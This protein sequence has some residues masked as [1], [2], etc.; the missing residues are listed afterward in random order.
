[1]VYHSTQWSDRR[2]VAKIFGAI[3]KLRHR[4][5]EDQIYFPT[6]PLRCL[7]RSVPRR[8]AGLRDPLV[9]FLAE[10]EAHQVG[11]LLD[12]T[13]F[14][15]IAE[16]RPMIAHP[17]LRRAAQLRKHQERARQVPSI[18]ASCPGKAG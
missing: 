16:L 4:V 17:G 8:R 1:M 5:Q 11:I 3:F 7:A 2:H 18:K 12:R 6:G 15:E 13:R 14:A 9:D 10:D